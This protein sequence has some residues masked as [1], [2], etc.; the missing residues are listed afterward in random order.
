MQCQDNEI[1]LFFKSNIQLL[2]FEKI[3]YLQIT[4]NRN[5]SNNSKYFAYLRI[6]QQ[7]LLPATVIVAVYGIE[8]SLR[9]V[10][11]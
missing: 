2:K 8:H 7:L 1:S 3:Q 4:G 6:P 10:Y 11:T 9:F 5:T